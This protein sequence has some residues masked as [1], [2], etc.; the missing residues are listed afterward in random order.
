MQK[1]SLLFISFMSGGQ[2]S[3]VHLGSIFSKT[4]NAE[5]EQL[6]AMTLQRALCNYGTI[7]KF[8]D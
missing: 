8:T 3:H 7:N 5:I 2:S 1:N 6:H 4:V